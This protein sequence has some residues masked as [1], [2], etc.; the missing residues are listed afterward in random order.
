[1]RE[2]NIA[3]KKLLNE[4]KHGKFIAERGEEIWNWS[5]AAGKLRRD[6]RAKF[7]KDFLGNGSKKVLEIGCGTGL[8]TQEIAKTNNLITAIDVSEDLINIAKERVVSRNVNFEIGNVHKTSFARGTFD[9]IVGSSVLHHL[10]VDG[11]LQEFYRILKPGGKLIFTEPNMLNPLI[12]L[13]K[14]I[15]WLK[16]KMGDS[17]DETA[18]I[19]W[20][21]FRKMKNFGFDNIEIIPFDFL[22]PATPAALAL[23]MKYIS[24]FMEKV[25]LLKEIAGS[26]KITSQKNERDV[27][28]NR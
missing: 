13:Q 6:K 14:N 16:K 28:K 25:P 20:M 11:A 7:F 22:H 9:Y 2:Q 15:P 18:F 19:R 3:D 27:R 17:P 10:N 24:D 26:L 1:M 23:G 21:L 4:I 12:A 5:S 8:F